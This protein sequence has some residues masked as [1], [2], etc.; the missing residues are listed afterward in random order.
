MKIMKFVFVPLNCMIQFV[1]ISE[2]RWQRSTISASKKHVV[3]DSPPPMTRRW[4]PGKSSPVE[5]CR[6]DQRRP[7]CLQ[8]PA[9]WCRDHQLVGLSIRFLFQVMILNLKVVF[10]WCWKQL[11]DI[12]WIRLGHLCFFPSWPSFVFSPT[13]HPIV[14]LPTSMMSQ[15]LQTP[16]SVVTFSRTPVDWIQRSF[17]SSVVTHI[18]QHHESQ[19][20][21]RHPWCGRVATVST[22]QYICTSLI[23][24]CQSGS[25]TLSREGPGLSKA[26]RPWTVLACIDP[27][28]EKD[29]YGM[30]SYGF[31]WVLSCSPESVERNEVS[32]VTS[33]SVISTETH[34]TLASVWG[35]IWQTS[36][37]FFS[38]NIPTSWLHQVSLNFG[39]P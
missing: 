2:L 34:L 22:V 1:A 38:Q 6:R 33:N 7:W 12:M 27:W 28:W 17:S 14:K 19:A 36:Q 37:V 10:S 5:W 30:I 25:P 24:I 8:L 35:L 32:W 9:M 39:S 20:Y 18:A 31:W 29:S 26:Q 23:C 13:I 3:P 16:A 11:S 4:L 21:I 15:H